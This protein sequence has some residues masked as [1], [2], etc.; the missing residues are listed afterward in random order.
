MC[1]GEILDPGRGSEEGCNKPSIIQKKDGYVIDI[2]DVSWAALFYL[3]SGNTR[4]N[5][6]EIFDPGWGTE[7]GCRVIAMANA[8]HLEKQNGKIRND[9]DGTDVLLL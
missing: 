2:T 6:D 9:Q 1:P 4:A 8:K 7:D 3:L 5:S